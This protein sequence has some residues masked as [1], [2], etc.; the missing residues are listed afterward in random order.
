M[1]DEYK[2]A[3]K[4]INEAIGR[5]SEKNLGRVSSNLPAINSPPSISGIAP[6]FV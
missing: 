4:L 1:V 6:K 5:F 3:S 2:S